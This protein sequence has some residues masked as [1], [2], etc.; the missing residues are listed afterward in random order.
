MS[1]RGAP[2]PGQSLGQE[3]QPVL[4][5]CLCE[6]A[7]CRRGN[8]PVE[9]ASALSKCLC[10]PAAGGLA[11]RPV[12]RA[13]ALSKCLCE[14]AAGGRGN[15]PVMSEAPASPPLLVPAEAGRDTPQSPLSRGDSGVCTPRQR[16]PSGAGS[17]LH[18]STCHPRE[19]CSCQVQEGRNPEA[20]IP[21]FVH[22]SLRARRRRARQSLSR[23]SQPALPGCLCEPAAGGRGNRPVLPCTRRS[24]ATAT[25]P[26]HCCE[27]GRFHRS[28]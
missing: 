11:N 14:L 21:A 3:T 25:H 27:K 28:P 5:K 10:E 7:A 9:R 6:S 18:T 23:Q 24:R 8:R 22:T 26:Y 20:R 12:E 19:T 2:A 16:Q 1:L 15:R 17:F 13:S 4:S